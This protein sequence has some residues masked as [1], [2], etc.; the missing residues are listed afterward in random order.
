MRDTGDHYE[1]ITKYIDDVLMIFK[2]PMAIL[3]QLKKPK[4]LYEF[5][6]VSSPEYYLGGDVKIKYCGNSIEKLSLSSETYIARICKKIEN[7]IKW[8][9]KGYMN[10]IDPNYHAELDELDFLT[11]DKIT[12]YPMMLGSSN[13]LV[14]LG[15][16][17][18]HYTICTL[19]RYIMIPRVGHMRAMKRVFEYLMQNHKFAIKY[20]TEEPDFSKLFHMV[21]KYELMIIS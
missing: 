15:R 6:G 7:L 5:K 16:Y 14:T 21:R 10:P 12:K 2:D 17:D 9:L 18:I 20:N 8:K 3:D 1:Y 11:G 4:G 13:W 19:E